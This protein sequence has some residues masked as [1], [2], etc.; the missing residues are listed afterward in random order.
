MHLIHT[1]EA[2]EN[3]AAVVSSDFPIIANVLLWITACIV[4]I[5]F[6]GAIQ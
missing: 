6:T 2:V 1:T 4:L 5:Y 3:P